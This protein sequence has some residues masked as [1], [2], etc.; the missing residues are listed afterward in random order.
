MIEKIVNAMADMDEDV[1]FEEIRS[2]LNTGTP[3]QAILADLQEG[4]DEVGRRFETKEYFLSDL[5][6]SGEIFKEAIESMGLSKEEESDSNIGTFL[7][8]TVYGDIHDIGKNIVIS[9]L[10]SNGFK[11]VDIGIN[12]K[13]EAFVKAVKEENPQ[14][15][16]MSCLLTTAFDYMKEAID[17][18]RAEGLTEGRLVLIGG[19]PVDAHTVEYTG[20]DDFCTNAQEGVKKSRK[21][22][23]V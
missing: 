17:A 14:I 6:L 8:G 9:V 2:Q 16:G 10:K 15:I 5:I 19:A 4:M 11:V 3:V 13:A 21:F 22:L 20:A 7:I 18:L 12:V 1:L 23:G